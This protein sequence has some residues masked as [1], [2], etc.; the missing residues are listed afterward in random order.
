MGL[1]R[2]FESSSSEEVQQRSSEYINLLM[3]EE[4]QQNGT[5]FD[6]MPVSDSAKL[7]SRRSLG[8]L[9]DGLAGTAVLR[10]SRTAS[11]D[12]NANSITPH[13]SRPVGEVCFDATD[14]P[15]DI[16]GIA[17][18]KKSGGS[19]TPSSA[20]GE[21]SDR[22]D[23]R[24]AANLN[25]ISSGTGVKAQSSG[26]GDLL[27]LVDLMGLESSPSSGA[28]PR[29][30]VA[31][32]SQATAPSRSDN[33]DIL[34]DL[35]GGTSISS[36]EPGPGCSLSGTVPSAATTDVVMPNNGLEVIPGNP[37]K[38]RVGDTSGL[39]D[40]FGLSGSTSPPVASRRSEETALGT[41]STPFDELVGDLTGSR[42]GVPAKSD[43]PSS[44]R[45][46]NDDDLCVDFICT[47]EQQ[48]SPVSTAVK[49]RAE[50]SNQSETELS[51]LL[52]EA[53]VPKYLKLSILPASGTS[54]PRKSKASV[55]QEMHVVPCPESGISGAG[56]KA[57]PL[58]MKCRISFTK[59]GVP[60][61]KFVNV[62]DFPSGLL[63]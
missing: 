57:R 20:V 61:Q 41:T 15:L 59:D 46:L 43:S 10:P 63:S 51:N 16:G 2:R 33:I 6:R 18:S 58:L 23:D 21:S 30:A 48:G 49:I 60:Q 26:P 38:A 44:M 9:G 45:V 4:W 54:V 29:T 8:T 3:T 52:F 28:L 56:A 39:D 50:F 53:A 7:A 13:A 24:P 1:L 14:V 42:S 55:A 22:L 12:D 62:S 34:A 40:V 36:T 31:A 37:L 47:R 17:T 32:P 35:L 25:G 19:V 5:I 27:D 11:T